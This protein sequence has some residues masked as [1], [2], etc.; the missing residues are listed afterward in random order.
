[1]SRDSL[2]RLQ[3]KTQI[4]PSIYDEVF[5]ADIEPKNLEGLF[6]QFNSEYH[7]LYRGRSMS[8]SDVVV[9]DPEGIPPF[10]GEITG[11]SP[12]GGDFKHRYTDLVEYNLAIETFREND[13]DFEAHDM[14]GLNIPAYESGAFFCND[15]GFERIE[16]DES[17]AQKPDNLMR[18]V[19]VEPN[20]EP[21][22][23]EIL[24]DLEHLQKAVDGYIEAVYL[25]DGTI[26]VANEESKLR[27]MEGNRRI[28]QTIIAGPFFVCGEGG[29]D[30][31]S[32]TDEEAARAM[33]RFA[34]P[35]QI[36]QA[37][38]EAD[39]GFTIITLG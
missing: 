18:V 13:I 9:I 5:N 19:Y 31:C 30:F 12:Y 28:G 11:H 34:E 10:V 6:V 8:V 7:P 2:Q 3:G 4:D 39:M 14:V 15:V 37:E 35:E 32:L 33:A 27:G 20:R 25:D 16:F 26:V 23:T 17:Q 38:V 24:P 36:S 22:E 29:D 21:F 1:M